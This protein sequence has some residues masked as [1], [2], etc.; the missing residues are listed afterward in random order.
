MAKRSNRLLP[1]RRFK[2]GAR[3]LPRYG[4][5][6]PVLVSRSLT[7]PLEPVPG[8]RKSPCVPSKGKGLTE[9]SCRSELV[10]GRGGARLRLCSAKG[11]AGPAV[12]VSSP[13]EATVLSRRF[14]ACVKR[15]KNAKTCAAKVSGRSALGG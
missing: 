1:K 15:S 9:S 13:R 5:K 8:H 3:K 7:G 12:P 4:G 10:L 14:C 11:K 6:G 2:T